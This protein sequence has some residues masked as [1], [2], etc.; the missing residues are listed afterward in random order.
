MN[1][2]R[3]TGVLPPT[4]DPAGKTARIARATSPVRHNDRWADHHTAMATLD[5]SIANTMKRF[6]AARLRP[7]SA[8]NNRQGSTT[9]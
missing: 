2:G 3:W 9:K 1:E 8:P 5:T 7:G 6:G 4:A